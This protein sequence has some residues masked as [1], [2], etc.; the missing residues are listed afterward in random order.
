MIPKIGDRMF[1]YQEIEQWGELPED[2]EICE[3]PGIAVDSQDRVFAFCRSERSV[4]I[5]NRDG[6]FLGSW[7]EGI[8]KRPH[9]IFIGPDDSVYC[10][11]DE[12]HTVKK[13]TPDGKL[14]L[15]LGPENGR[16]ADTG[17]VPG[18]P[19]SV[20]RAGPPFNRPTDIA[21]SSENEIYVSD[22]YGN[23]RVHK[24]SSDG[25]LLQSWGEP[26]AGPGQFELVH[27]VCV[28]SRGLIYVADRRNTRIQVF[29]SNGDYRTEWLEVWWPCA[30]CIDGKEHMF[31]AELGGIFMFG[32]EAHLDKP[33]ARI[34]IRDLSGNVM[35]EYGSK[36]PYGSG[37]FFAPHSIAIDS[38]G[39]FYVGE[40]TH[41]YSRGQ[42]PA[43]AK[44]L[45]KFT[46]V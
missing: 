23:A 20:V 44:V 37:R 15:T 35:A 32:P 45:R 26:G 29:S 40:V 18:D 6:R 42:A 8:F 2:W 5:F 9:M 12:G 13:F 16:P 31:V 25:R 39:D 17:Y 1:D 43:G 14:L 34:T 38:R 46:R 19:K 3:V 10:V 7:G 33:T 21:L 4:V 41:S 30:M 24:F 22:G 11:D 27:G 36:D 28:D